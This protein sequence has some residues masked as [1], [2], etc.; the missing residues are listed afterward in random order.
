MK[1]SG[2]STKEIMGT[3]VIQNLAKEKGIITSMSR[4]G[5]CQ[6]NAVIK[7]FHS[8]LKSE[9]SITLR[10]A[11]ISNSKVVKIVNQYMYY[12]NQ[13]RIQANLNYLSPIEFAEQ[14]A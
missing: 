9:G 11:S 4:K 8:S 13:M 12:Y 2:I 3:L 10:R 5:N 7:S 14:I 1:Q 6:D